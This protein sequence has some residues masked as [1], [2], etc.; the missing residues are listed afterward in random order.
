MKLDLTESTSVMDRLHTFYFVMD[1]HYQ[2]YFVGCSYQEKK[3]HFNNGLLRKLRKT[4]ISIL[5]ELNK[6]FCV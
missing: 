1:S 6:L 5:R 3:C 2:F 4:K